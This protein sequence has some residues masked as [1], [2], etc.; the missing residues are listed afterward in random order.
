MYGKGL[1]VANTATGIALLPNT[2]DN[3]V[4][5]AIALGLL[6]AGIAIFAISTVLARKNRQNA[7]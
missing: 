6:V 5:F 1:G 3:R 4:L 2:G 7:Q